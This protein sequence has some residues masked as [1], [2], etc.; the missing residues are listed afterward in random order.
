MQPYSSTYQKGM[1]PIHG[2]PLLEYIITG[3]IYANLRDLILVVGYRKEQVINYFKDGKQWNANIEYIEQKE[4]NG[5][6]GAVLL[7]EK[8]IKNNHFFLV[9]GDILV[10]YKTY[11]MVYDIFKKEQHDF[12]LVS[13][14]KEDLSRGGAIYCDGDYCLEIVEK[15]PKTKGTSNLNNCGIFILSREIFEVLKLLEPSKRGEIEIPSAINKG[16][17]E[18]SWK[19]FVAKLD[20]DIFRGDFGDKKIYEELKSNSKWLDKL[21]V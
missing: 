2:K 14:Y 16:I 7:C 20:K 15:E 4:L 10:P 9:W 3:L 11:K 8:L 13:N 17:R 6:G 18:K 21:D 19:I 5:T 12:I 1:L